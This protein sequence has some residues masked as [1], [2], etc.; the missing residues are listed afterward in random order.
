MIQSGGNCCFESSLINLKRISSWPPAELTHSFRA[1][2]TSS[3]EQFSLK[4]V[5]SASR[6]TLFTSISS[7]VE[8]LLVNFAEK[9]SADSDAVCEPSPIFSAALL[10]RSSFKFIYIY[11]LFSN[12]RCLLM[13]FHSLPKIS[14]LPAN[15]GYIHHNIVSYHLT[16]DF[17]II[18]VSSCQ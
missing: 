7:R 6:M 5:S 10:D 1:V 8:K 4:L 13:I 17:C 12:C 14:L 16:F 18:D 15:I 3:K 2:V 11:K 9:I